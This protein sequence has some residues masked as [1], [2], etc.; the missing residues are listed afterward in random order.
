ME[1]CFLMEVVP[2]G[3]LRGE[4]PFW[5]HAPAKVVILIPQGANCEK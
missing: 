5:P 2:L 1:S 4:F 3:D